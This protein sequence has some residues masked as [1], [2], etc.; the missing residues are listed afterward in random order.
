MAQLEFVTLTAK[1][2]IILANY[3]DKIYR[4]VLVTLQ[5]AHDFFQT[6]GVRFAPSEHGFTVKT[7]TESNPGLAF[8]VHLQYHA[9]TYLH[10]YTY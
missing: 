8:Q 6:S 4:H 3:T 5:C 10:N 1:L 9:I 2:H 7:L